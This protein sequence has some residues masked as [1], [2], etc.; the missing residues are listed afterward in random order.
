[1]GDECPFHIGQTLVYK[2]S[3]K[4][5][6]YTRPGTGLVPYQ[7]YVVREIP[8]GLYILVEGYNPPGGGIHW[9]EFI[10]AEKR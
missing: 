4:G 1:M 9:T 10:A 6:G 5:M 2:P 3:A 8:E 7:E